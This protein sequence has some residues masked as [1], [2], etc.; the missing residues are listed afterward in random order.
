MKNASRL[1]DALIGFVGQCAWND[2]RHAYVLVWMVIG[3]INEGRLNLTHWLVPVETSAQFAQSTQRR[4]ARWLH[5]PR[6]PPTLLYRPL[7]AAALADWQEPVLYLSLDTTLL[8]EQFC[9]IRLAVVYRGRA[10]LL[11]W[12]GLEHRSSSVTFLS[13]RDL[14]EKIAPV[15]PATVKIVLLAERGLVDG[16]LARYLS[17]QLNWHYRLRLTSNCWVWKPGKGW[18][19]L[20]Q[21]HLNRGE[22]ILLHRV[23]LFKGDPLVGVHLALARVEHN[24]ELWLILSSEPTTLQSLQEYGLRFDIEEN[25]WDDNSNG[26]E[27]ED[28]GLRSAVALSRLCLVTAVATLY[29]TL[30]GTAVVAAKQRRWVDPHWFRGMSYLKIGWNWLKKALTQ[31]WQFFSIRSLSFHR[32]PDPVKA[33]RRQYEHQRYRLEFQVYSFDYAC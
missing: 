12:R 20:T 11:T 32:D 28:A 25:F 17:G 8:W 6:I 23:R 21:F 24:G 14:L 5:N 7:I 10:I 19:Q 29:L 30:Q 13:Y 1:Y 9:I 31:G 3:L 15:L 16:Q 18:M 2:Q 26:F 27:L 4:F 33:S 22:A